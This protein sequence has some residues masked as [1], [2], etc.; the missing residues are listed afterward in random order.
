MNPEINPNMD[1]IIKKAFESSGYMKPRQDFLHEVMTKIEKQATVSHS[2]T[3]SSPIISTKGWGIISTILLT[4]I[5]LVFRTE[6]ENKPS[7]FSLDFN[8]DFSTQYF[9]IFMSQVF[10][11]GIVIMTIFFLVQIWFT[12]KKVNKMYEVT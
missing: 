8:A 12:I 3:T 7:L 5:F 1:K 11:F 6:K 4:L 2:V 10:V 9:S